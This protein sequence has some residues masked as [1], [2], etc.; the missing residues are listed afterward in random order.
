MTYEQVLALYGTQTQIAAALGISQGTVSMWKKVV[1][2]HY[3]YQLEII[4]NRI[5]LVDDELRAPRNLAAGMP[6]PKIH[7]T[8]QSVTDG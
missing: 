1:P 8:H 4:T 2:P 7:L 5:L 3:Q 6:K